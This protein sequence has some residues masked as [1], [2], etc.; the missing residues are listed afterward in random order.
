MILSTH[1][2]SV[3]EA[4]GCP[5]GCPRPEDVGPLDMKF[6]PYPGEPYFIPD[7]PGIPEKFPNADS[8]FPA[9]PGNSEPSPP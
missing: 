2:S 7:S 1:S 3:N 4:P 5:V 6:E 9:P 8:M